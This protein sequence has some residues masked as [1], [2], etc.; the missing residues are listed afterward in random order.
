MNDNLIPI[1]IQATNHYNSEFKCKVLEKLSHEDTIL[2][3]MVKKIQAHFSCDVLL[4]ISK[5]SCDDS[6][7]EEAV[8]LGILCY[9]GDLMDLV[10]RLM[11][12]AESIGCTRFVRVMGN[13]PLF[14][15]DSLKRLVRE[16][17]DSGAEF[18]YNEHKDG[19]PW[20]MGAEV[21]ET[22]L[23]KKLLSMPLNA[24]QKEMPMLYIRQD[25]HKFKLWVAKS[26]INNH[27][28]KL[29]L[30]TKKDL[31]LLRDLVYHIKHPDLESVVNYLDGHPILAKSN[32]ESPPKE[33]GL[34]KLFLHPEKIKYLN[35]SVVSGVDLTYP[36]SVELSLTNRC[37]LKCIWCSDYMLRQRQGK[38]E[39]LDMDS[40]FR[41]FEDLKRGGTKGIV[42]E[43]GG[44]PSIFPYFEKV[45]QHLAEINLPCGLITNGSMELTPELLE[46]FEWIRVSLDASTPQEYYELKKRDLFEQ[47][48]LNIYKYAKICPT[49]GVGYV[50]TGKNI[51]KL[52]TLVLR[53]RQCGASYVQFRP[54]VDCPEL[55]PDG[56]DLSY[57]KHYERSDFSIIIDG[58]TE[59]S[60]RGNCGLSCKAHS[61]TT[62]I[63]ADGAVYLCGRMNIHEWMK[64]IGN[65]HDNSFKEIWEGEE[66]IRQSTLVADSSFCKQ[67]CPQCRLTKFN[68]MLERLSKVKTPNF[69]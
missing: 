20:G 25:P 51:E 3:F 40:L 53:L 33:V 42:I 44:E 43:G 11:G 58:M 22:R 26:D 60:S 27:Q 59:N 8:K 35:K 13:S 49:V 39:E 46:S 10:S 62:V 2:S 15:I 52:E 66:R 1:I 19:V 12:A 16:H 45:I 54:V 21:I 56:I 50:V 32:T 57:L 31:L 67:H 18:S 34:E 37:N 6:L 68:T 69:I 65:I 61:I 29:V 55:D 17:D 23:L 47:I 9:R 28:I 38:N 14:D 41:L 5:K 4:A 36:I 64:P 24:D 30:D 63:S 48:L 7:E